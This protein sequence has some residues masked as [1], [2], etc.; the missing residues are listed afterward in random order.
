MKSFFTKTFLTALVLWCSCTVLAQKTSVQ[1]A[2]FST[3]NQS[4]FGAGN[5]TSIN[6]RYN[7]FQDNGIDSKFF[8]NPMVNGVQCFDS[9]GRDIIN[10]AI[11]AVNVFAEPN[12]P[13][14]SNYCVGAKFEMKLGLDFDAYVDITI[15]GGAANVTYPAKFTFTYPNDNSFGCED[16]IWISTK[17]ELLST[18]QDLRVIDPLF[19]FKLGTKVKPGVYGAGSLCFFAGCTGQGSFDYGNPSFAGADGSN[20]TGLLKGGDYDMFKISSSTG[21]SFPWNLYPVIPTPSGFPNLT[22]PL[23]TSLIPGFEDAT[24]ITGSI[25]NPFSNLNGV[26]SMMANKLINTSTSDFFDISFDPM[27]FTTYITGIPVSI[28]TSL[29]PLSANFTAISTPLELDVTQ[30][31]SFTLDPTFPI[32]LNLGRTLRWEEYNADGTVKIRGGNS[33]TIT[34]FS[35]GNKLKIIGYPDKFATSIVP[36]FKI[37]AAFNSNFEENFNLSLDLKVAEGSFNFPAFNLGTVCNDLMNQLGIHD[38]TLRDIFV[39]ACSELSDISSSGR[40]GFGPYGPDKWNLGD[41]AI[42]V[43][44]KDFTMGGFNAIA[45]SSFRLKPDSLPPTLVTKNITVELLRNDTTLIPQQFVQ[46]ASDNQGGTIEYISVVPNRFDCSSIGNTITVQVTISDGRCNTRT[47]PA[48]VTITDGTGPTAACKTGVNVYL[49]SS[50]QVTVPG[51][52]INNNSLGN[53]ISS[54]ILS[55]G[56]FNCTHV[57]GSSIPT[58]LTVTDSRGRTSACTGSVIVRDT[59]KPLAKCKLNLTVYLDTFGMA[60]VTP[61]MINNGS[62][63]A[64]GIASMTLNDSLFDCSDQGNHTVIMTVKDTKNNIKYCTST[65]TISDNDGVAIKCPDNVF[66]NSCEPIQLF[67]KDP[68]ITDNCGNTN[69]LTWR[70]IFNSSGKGS[71]S[72]FNPGEN[73]QIIYEAR[74]YYTNNPSD[75]CYFSLRVTAS[76]P[77]QITCPPSQTINVNNQFG[78]NNNI[79][80]WNLPTVVA[81]CSYTLSIISG[82]HDPGSLQSGLFPLGITTNTFVVNTNYS[83]MKDTCSFNITVIDMRPPQIK[84]PDNI[85]VSANAGACNKTVTYANP[86]ILSPNSICFPEQIKFTK[87]DGLDSGSAFPIGKDTVT[88]RATSFYGY[89]STCSF[90]ISVAPALVCPQNMSVFTDPNS[91]TALVN[92]SLGTQSC[93]LTDI[94]QTE[95]FPSGVAIPVGTTTNSFL[96]TDVFGNISQCSFTITVND[97]S[98]ASITCPPNITVN[99]TNA[100]TCAGYPVYPSPIVSNACDGMY[101]VY[102]IAG[103]AS[104]GYFDIGVTTVTYVVN[105]ELSRKDTCSFTVTVNDKV[106]SYLQCPL[107]IIRYLPPANSC[108]MVINYNLPT[109]YDICTNATLQQINGLPSGSAFGPGIHLMNF[110][111]IDGYGNTANCSFN[112]TV[113][114]TV[115][116][117]IN[118]PANITVNGIKNSNDVCGAIVQYSAPT[119]SDNCSGILQRIEGFGSGAFFLLGKDTVK[120]QFTDPSGNTASCSFTIT[121]NDCIPE[122]TASC[123]N[124]TGYVD[125]NCEHNVMATD[126]YNDVIDNSFTYALSPTGPYGVGIH[127]VTLTVTNQIGSMSSCNAI[128]TIKDTIAPT[129]QCPANITVNATLGTCG[130]IVNYTKPIGIDNCL[131][132]FNGQVSGIGPGSSFPVGTTTNVFKVTDYSGLSDTCHQTITVIDNI[133]PEIVCPANQVVRIS[134]GDCGAIISFTKPIGTD[135]CS[136]FGNAQIAG[137]GPNVL[138]PKGIT[139][140]IF[141]TTDRSN[142]KDT[143][144]FTVTV[145]QDSA[146]LYQSACEQYSWNGTIYT[147]SGNYVFTTTNANGCN[148]TSVLHLTISNS[149]GRNLIVSACKSYTWTKNGNTYTQNGQYYHNN[150]CDV[151]TLTITF[152]P[153]YSYYLDKDNDRY[154]IQTKDSCTNPGTGWKQG[155]PLAGFDCND[156]NAS[157]YPFA[158]DSLCNGIDNDCDGLK[159]EDFVGVD[160]KICQ[161]GV[162]LNNITGVSIS[163]L[164]YRDIN[165]TSVTVYWNK[166]SIATSYSVQYRQDGTG[167]AWSELNNISDTFKTIT[168]L[169]QNRK[170]NW[171]VRAKCGSDYSGYSTSTFNTN[172]VPCADPPSNLQ[173]LNVTHNY[174]LLN[175]SPVPGAVNYTLQSYHSNTWT[176]FA[177]TEM[178]SFQWTNLV[179]N[180]KYHWRIWASCAKSITSEIKYHDFKTN[181]APEPTCPGTEDAEP[182]NNIATAKSI[183]FNT[184]IKG[185]I[186]AAGDKDYY[187]FTVA[188]GGSIKITL[189]ELTK[190][191]DIRL[192]TATGVSVAVSKKANTEDEKIEVTIAAGQYYIAVFGFTAQTY[193]AISCYN[194]KVQPISVSLTEL[195]NRNSVWE[196]VTWPVPVLNQLNILSKNQKENMDIKLLSI[197][198]RLLYTAKS[199]GEFYTLDMSTYAAGAYVLRISDGLEIKNI[200][201]TK[202]D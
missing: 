151:D 161:N 103:A 66:V 2:T 133:P 91:C 99:I 128:I 25:T 147:Q 95:G 167:G 46:S 52:S 143:C 154:A 23:T 3:T 16:D 89:T 41:W 166:I 178:T 98:A 82:I 190:D 195:E 117:K 36:T 131:T 108:E 101:N 149:R 45:G 72:V 150:G 71:G 132:N 67:W 54:Y 28:G 81:D 107:S 112:I 9:K 160:C 193:D 169:T 191:Y 69:L 172:A 123:K 68:I 32:D 200:K 70:Q 47:L 148:S 51:T 4:I 62:S 38:E 76:G 64:C 34:G 73:L 105:D 182:N 65:V 126:V 130:A 157:V 202:V 197:D 26:T 164:N 124:I 1:N 114:D 177:V 8:T 10:T 35:M 183:P 93:G 29:G 84:C 109:Y 57:T 140:N 121:V 118:C 181:A 156:N 122:A 100:N 116:P 19:E 24:H 175:W 186:G 79:A 192:Y 136:V 194:L 170:Y 199:F 63:D 106:L 97:T 187:G 53:C 18:G 102:R 198:G 129:V 176:T 111:A 144:Q 96:T 171:R 61:A 21:I 90:T 5:A 78:C 15:Q 162:V 11:D 196:I 94:I 135:N 49:N 155:T 152:L 141:T 22:L 31:N 138:F 110:R 33:Q 174:A 125:Q 145:L 188:K 80:S 43:L 179:P 59:I 180:V 60:K 75:Q 189:T 42:D 168:G 139:T 158:K 92:Y 77:P 40:I 87:I 163:G 146:H 113:H 142:L 104:G 159:D 17:A 134:A 48:T 39:T 7:L 165:T 127:N 50:G 55:A 37:N 137:L 14:S 30:N 153:L 12:I 201:I 27:P 115:K 88:Y 185:K 120:Y 119:A 86:T 83:N 13:K 184:N 56:S 44:N 74:E 20:Y 6:K 173:A 58:T 85:T